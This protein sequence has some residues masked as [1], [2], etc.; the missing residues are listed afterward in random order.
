MYNIHDSTVYLYF[1]I[2]LANKVAAHL[3]VSMPLQPSEVSRNPGL[4]GVGDWLAASELFVAH[5]GSVAD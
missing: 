4:P 5:S 2:I 1:F 3:E